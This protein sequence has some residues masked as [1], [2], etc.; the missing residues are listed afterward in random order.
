MKIRVLSK[1]YGAG[2]FGATM[3]GWLSIL[4]GL[5]LPLGAGVPTARAAQGEKTKSAAPAAADSPGDAARGKAIFEKNG[6]FYCHGYLGQGGTPAGP[7]IAPDTLPWQVIAAYIRKPAGEMPPFSSKL[8]PDKDV[9]D[10]YAY[11]KSVPGPAAPNQ[12]PTFT[13]QGH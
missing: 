8:V 11:L 6:C 13:K 2:L 1:T 5:L 3:A 12:I 7:R 10:I 4:I 9:Q